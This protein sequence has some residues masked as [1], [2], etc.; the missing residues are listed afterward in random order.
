MLHLDGGPCSPCEERAAIQIKQL[1]TKY[2]AIGTARNAI[3]DPFVHKLPSEIASHIIRLSLPTLNNRKEDLEDIHQQWSIIR[4]GW[5][6]LKLGSVCRKWRQLAWAT[7]NLW[8][9]LYIRI[10]ASITPSTAESLPDLLREWLGRSGAVPLTIYFFP[11]EDFLED[12]TPDYI[13]P[14]T[15]TL[16]TMADLVID[17]LSMHLGRWRNLHLRASPA[18]LERFSCSTEPKQ[19]VSLEL[20]NTK[21]EKTPLLKFM[22]ESE[23]N[24]THLKLVYFPPTLINVRWDNITHAT[25]SRITIDEGLDFLR[26]AP[27]LEYYC[28]YMYERHDNDDIGLNP[29]LHPQLC[30]LNLSTSS[31]KL[32]D[33][34]NLPSLQEWIQDTRG[35]NLAVEAT[36]CCPFLSDHGVPSKY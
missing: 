34:I 12:D 26:R 36:A 22:M 29:I 23:L 3:H 16:D 4:K 9:T 11:Y 15:D 32:L 10:K 33:T 8:T 18:I 7:P 28:V 19:L 1:K 21:E 20:T 5:A 30:S 13:N 14:W 25:I 24:L 31:K 2:D 35:R 17:L 6:L 27:S